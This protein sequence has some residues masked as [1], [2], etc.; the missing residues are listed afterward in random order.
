MQTDERYSPL[1]SEEAPPAHLVTA[2]HRGGAVL[3]LDVA[4][5][6][7]SAQA[8]ELI[9]ILS[10]LS[11]STGCGYELGSCWVNTINRDQV[12]GV[13]RGIST[14]TVGYIQMKLPTAF[15]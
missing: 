6:R 15:D 11:I 12:G 5:P 1:Q 13:N 8:A 7:L 14:G 9:T 2:A 3:S 4:A 10:S